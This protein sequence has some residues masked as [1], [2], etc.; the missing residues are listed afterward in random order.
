MKLQTIRLTVIGTVTAVIRRLT[1]TQYVEQ[2][3]ELIEL[4]TEAPPAHPTPLAVDATAGLAR[5]KCPID[6]TI[7]ESALPR[8]RDNPRL[9]DIPAGLKLIGCENADDLW[10]YRFP[11]GTAASR[12]KQAIGWERNGGASGGNC[13]SQSVPKDRSDLPLAASRKETKV[14]RG[15]KVLRGRPRLNGE[16][17]AVRTSEPAAASGQG[18]RKPRPDHTVRVLGTP[19]TQGLATIGDIIGMP[20]ANVPNSELVRKGGTEGRILVKESMAKLG[21]NDAKML[22]MTTW[23]TESAAHALRMAIMAAVRNGD[24]EVEGLGITKAFID[25]HRQKSATSA[26]AA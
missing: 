23:P 8:I 26:A 7:P 20:A 22:W 10:N 21:L 13:L 16:G 6:R 24:P 3:V 9:L 15:A 2:P 14:P 1:S 11:A 4:H 18:Q 17:A 5:P 12:L 19:A 25:E